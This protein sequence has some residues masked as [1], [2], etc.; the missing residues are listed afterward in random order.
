MKRLAMVLA[1]GFAVSACSGKKAPESEP[2]EDEVECQT[3]SDCEGNLQ[4]LGN[5]CVDT[6][7]KAI[8]SNPSN[9]VTPE[10][11]KRE[12]ELRQRAHTEQVDKSLDLPE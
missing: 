8:Y 4:C 10:K 5:E 3:N 1:L 7:S 2:E 12:V 9:A 11:V 6:S